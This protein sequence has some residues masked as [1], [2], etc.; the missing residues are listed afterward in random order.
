MNE[1][2]FTGDTPIMDPDKP[3]RCLWY[4]MFQQKHW[5]GDLAETISSQGPYDER[6]GAEKMA[7]IQRQ[8]GNHILAIAPAIF[9]DGDY[10]KDYKPYEKKTMT[11]TS[12][13]DAMGDI[14]ANLA[15][16]MERIGRNQILNEIDI[17]AVGVPLPNHMRYFYNAP[18]EPAPA[19]VVNPGDGIKK[20][21]EAK[22]DG[23]R[24]SARVQD[25]LPA[26]DTTYRG[27][28]SQKGG[29]TVVKSNSWTGR[30]KR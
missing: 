22:T 9:Q 3:V 23:I 25:R 1:I 20:A 11:P 21:L 17:R 18:A 14:Y 6:D 2:S 12:I 4:V 29:P 24:R 13:S 30:G 5:N 16:D 27:L 28:R 7:A 15:R 8:Y 26:R 19:I 10:I